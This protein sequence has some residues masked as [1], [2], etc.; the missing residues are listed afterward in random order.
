MT[1]LKSFQLALEFHLKCLS[2]EE[3]SLAQDHPSIGLSYFHISRDYLALQQ[4]KNALNY[5][6]KAIQ[7]TSQFDFTNLYTFHRFIAEI[8]FE[9]EQFQQALEYF[10]KSLEFVDDQDKSSMTVVYYRIGSIH[11]QL[12][13]YSQALI[14]FKK[15]LDLELETL[16]HDAQTIATTYSRLATVYFHLNQLTDALEMGEKALNQLLKTLSFHD[17]EVNDARQVLDQLKILQLLRE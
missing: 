16:D 5:A 10:E 14:F 7:Q 3:K 11:Q 8:Y 12:S 13:N 4:Y 15:T 17:P 6:F 9:Q 2:I 1:K